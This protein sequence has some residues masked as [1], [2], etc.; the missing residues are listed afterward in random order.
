MTDPRL[1]SAEEPEQYP[2]VAPER[3]PAEVLAEMRENQTAPGTIVVPPLEEDA[4]RRFSILYTVTVAVLVLLLLGIG[5]WFL[6][7]LVDR[8]ARLNA[9]VADQRDEIHSLTDDL[10]ASTENAQGLYDQLLSLGQDPQGTDPEVL[11]P[12]PGERGPEGPPGAPGEDSTV[13]GPPGPP[14]APGEPGTDGQ[15]GTPGT[16]GTAGSTGPQ[17]PPGEP[18]ATGA[19]GPQ[20]PPGPTCPEGYTGTA[21][22]VL[23]ADP[24]TGLPAPQPAFICTP[25]PTP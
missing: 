16:D 8:N 24:V 20:G 15:P 4:P 22:T 3:D 19:T 9:L 2:A 21:T 10:L 6:V 17:G 23:V 14:G 1:D 12:Q 7:N 25:T 13:P 18:G 11:T 5:G